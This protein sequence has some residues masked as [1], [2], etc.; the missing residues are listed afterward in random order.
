MALSPINA[1]RAA[2]WVPLLPTKTLTEIAAMEHLTRERV[3]QVLAE[4]G[5]KASAFAR[6]RF[7]GD[8]VKHA[9]ARCGKRACVRA[10]YREEAQRLR[11]QRMAAGYYARCHHCGAPLATPPRQDGK[12]SFCRGKN[13]CHAA[14][15][16]WLYHNN[17]VVR[18]YM[19]ACSWAGYQAQKQGWS[20]ERMRLE[21][22]KRY[23]DTLPPPTVPVRAQDAAH[24]AEAFALRKQGLSERAIA[25]RL[26]VGRSTV[27]SWLLGTRRPSL[28]AQLQEAA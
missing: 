2:R 22:A 28:K 21:R 13:A 9:G 20:V 15:Q 19:L 24:V 27:N 10:D 17:P 12:P 7:C 3:R 18:A 16:S 8:P 11:E 23:R 25:A 5:V 26:G 4:A 14:R 1:E 6:C